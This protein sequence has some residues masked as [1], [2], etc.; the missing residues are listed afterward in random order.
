MSP[1]RRCTRR[2]VLLCVLLLPAV[3]GCGWTRLR[4]HTITLRHNPSRADYAARQLARMGHE[5]IAVLFEGTVSDGV[6]ERRA[7]ARWL[8]RA[9]RRDAPPP[10]IVERVKDLLQDP[11]TG[12]REAAMDSV[13]QHIHSGLPAAAPARERTRAALRP[14]VGPLVRI[15]GTPTD[16]LRVQAAS[17]LS[18]VAAFGIRDDAIAGA[19]VRGLSDPDPQMIRACVAGLPHVDPPRG[20]LDALLDCFARNL[21]NPHVRP[22]LAN[23]LWARSGGE[24]SAL[25]AALE[26]S[27]PTRRVAAAEAIA[28]LMSRRSPLATPWAEHRR[29]SVAKLRARQEREFDPAVRA[30]LETS[31]RRIEKAMRLD[32]T[33]PLR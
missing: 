29:P 21:D 18:A 12:V 10:A 28:D 24:P 32:S 1:T 9:F 5:G 6:A 22:A 3:A 23:A 25:F 13:M 17:T 11:D 19:L 14:L 30:R 31:I 20:A 8:V 26:V 33:R 16:P 15:R 2:A 27:N 4:R 7:S